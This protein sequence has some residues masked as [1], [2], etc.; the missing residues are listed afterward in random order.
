MRSLC[1][2]RSCSMSLCRRVRSSGR[3]CVGTDIR[4]WENECAPL[5]GASIAAKFGDIETGLSLDDSSVGVSE[6]VKLGEA[7][8]SDVGVKLGDAGVVET[9]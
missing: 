1:L 6:V 2:L 8:A 7:E 9:G 3:R 4:R 5:T